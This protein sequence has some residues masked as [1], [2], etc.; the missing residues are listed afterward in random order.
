MNTYTLF[1]L[2]RNLVLVYLAHDWHTMYKIGV[3]GIKQL[4]LWHLRRFMRIKHS[5]KSYKPSIFFKTV[6][7]LQFFTKID[8]NIKI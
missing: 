4:N 8:D 6:A 3:F 7:N 5:F 1:G 2:S